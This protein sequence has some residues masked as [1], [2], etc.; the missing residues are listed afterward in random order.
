MQAGGSW[1]AVS[2]NGRFAAVTNYRENRGRSPAPR[3]RGEFVRDFVISNEPP[4]AFAKQIDNGQYAGFSFLAAAGD[5][6]VYCSNR[7]GEPKI[8][9]AGVYGLSNASLDTPWPKLK[10]CRDKLADIV[11]ENNT[12]LTSLFRI[13]ADKKT[14]AA[15]EITDDSLPFDVARSLSAPFIVTPEYG[16]RCSTVLLVGNDGLLEISER[17]FDSTGKAIGDSSFR[18]SIEGSEASQVSQSDS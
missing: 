3:S 7:G 13:V 18:Y 1:L 8:L 9:D 15:N 11:R 14:A 6:L 4:L 17:R 5:E 10:R 12:T 16:T 2:R